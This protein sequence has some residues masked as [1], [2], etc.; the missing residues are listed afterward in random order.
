MRWSPPAPPL[1]HKRLVPSKRGSPFSSRFRERRPNSI[2]KLQTTIWVRRPAAAPAVTDSSGVSNNLHCGAGSLQRP[3]SRNQRSGH[4]VVHHPVISSDYFVEKLRPL[5][6][7][8]QYHPAKEVYAPV[9]ALPQEQVHRGTDGRR[10]A[11]P[12]QEAPRTLECPLE[13][14]HECEER[15][16]TN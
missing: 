3:C 12:R 16:S 1:P 11:Y 10:P 15:R 14:C 6:A 5:H 7:V 2:R 8:A 4:E 13:A 9:R